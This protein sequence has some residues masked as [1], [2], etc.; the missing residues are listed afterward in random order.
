MNIG[1]HDFR[2]YSIDSVGD[3]VFLEQQCF[4]AYLYDCAE[5]DYECMNEQDR[6][7][8]YCDSIYILSCV[9]KDAEA[10]KICVNTEMEAC[11][12]G[13]YKCEKKAVM[14]CDSLYGDV[15]GKGVNDWTY[16]LTEYMSDR[17]KDSYQGVC[18]EGWRIPTVND[19]NSLLQMIG[20]QYGVESKKIALALF[21]EDATGFGIEKDVDELWVDV[22]DQRISVSSSWWTQFLVA[23][24]RVR[25]VTLYKERGGL[26]PDKV[27]FSDVEELWYHSIGYTFYAAPVRCIKE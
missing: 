18:P 3:T 2:M 21:G 20:G 25:N 17:N 9:P 26:T 13:D 22:E 19:W 23:D 7:R 12:S 14:K 10:E 16:G 6:V 1:E 4:D 5:D 11:D 8:N 27:W 15:C 24:A